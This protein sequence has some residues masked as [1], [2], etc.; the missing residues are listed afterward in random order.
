MYCQ[1][2]L[3]FIM[4]RNKPLYNVTDP[5]YPGIVTSLI[6]IAKASLGIAVYVTVYSVIAITAS[7][8]GYEWV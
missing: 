7:G 5:D 2:L 6:G 8:S 4:V 3:P 1:Y